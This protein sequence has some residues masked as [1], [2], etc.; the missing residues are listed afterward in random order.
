MIY[1]IT[2]KLNYELKR[3]GCYV[4]SVLWIFAQTAEIELDIIDVNEIYRLCRRMGYVGP[5]AHV[6]EGGINGI[7]QMASVITKKKVY[8][9]LSNI[10]LSYNNIIARYSREIRPR[11]YNSHFCPVTPPDNVLYDP[12]P[13]SK[14]VR[15]GG[16]MDYRYVWSEKL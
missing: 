4:L 16:I 8:M 14:T 6:E 3:W 15:E 9:K 12:Y 10:N 7:A 5:E 13:N 2:P 11:V 1:Q